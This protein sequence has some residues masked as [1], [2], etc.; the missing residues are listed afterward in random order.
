MDDIVHVVYENDMVDLMI[1]TNKSYADY[2]YTTKSGKHLL[3]V[4]LKK[5]MYGC[6]KAAQLFWENLSS[7]LV[8]EMNFTVNPY[9]SCV[10]NKTIDGKQCTIVWHVDDL[11]IAHV[12]KKVVNAVI[13]QL[14]QKYGKMSMTVGRKYKYVGMN[15]IYNKEGTVT[16]KTIDYVKEAIEEFPEILDTEEKTPATANLFDVREGILRLPAD[17]EKSFIE[18]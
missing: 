13:A 5:A 4:Q 8:K 17:K 10:A 3:Y 16:I 9:D 6:M 18:L 11:K 1:Q 14:E 15:I 7:Y 2:V 12:S